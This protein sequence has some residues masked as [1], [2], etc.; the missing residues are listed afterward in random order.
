MSEKNSHNK[1]NNYRTH[2]CELRR[3][4]DIIIRPKCVIYPLFTL[5]QAFIHRF[6]DILEG[7]SYSCWSF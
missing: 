4:T 5:K 7:C 2:F 3:E 1:L 6:D